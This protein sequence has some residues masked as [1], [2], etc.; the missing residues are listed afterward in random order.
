MFKVKN[1]VL[2]IGIFI[3]FMFLLHN[4]IRAF[5]QP[6]PKYDDFCIGR[7]Y[8]SITK[9]L[10]DGQSCTITT[11]IMEEEQDCYKQK[12][13]PVHEYDEFGCSIAVKDCD[14]CQLDYENALNAHNKVVFIIALI[15][16]IITLIVGYTK[17][18]VEPVGSSL[19]A[20]GIGAIVYGTISNWENLGNLGR[21][22]LLLLA[23]I[24]LV[25]IALRLN[26]KDQ[27]RFWQKLGI[28]N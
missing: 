3:V 23:F 11:K 17:L 26:T 18:S 21:F 15:V 25:W 13:Q 19:M 4:G 12:G 5:Y 9:P 16:G 28:K 6:S 1:L 7:F 2:G 14:F 27:K 22:L 8:P 20:S 10:P 24:L